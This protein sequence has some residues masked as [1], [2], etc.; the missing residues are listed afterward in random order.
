M[1]ELRR[2]IAR[3]SRTTQPFVLAFIDV[4]RLKATNDSLG[5]GAGDELLRRVADTMRAHLRS[6]DLIVRVGGDEFLCGVA[7]LSVEVA[8][9]RFSRV[10]ESL[11]SQHAGVTVGLAELEEGDSVD[12][13]VARA[14]QALRRERAR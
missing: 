4:D 9:A 1:L 12:D 7:N 5:H 2:E 14:D 3:A 13:L 8:A 11:A 10:N 6:Y